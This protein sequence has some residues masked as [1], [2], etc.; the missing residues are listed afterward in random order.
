MANED[1]PTLGKDVLRLSGHIS[2]IE[3][4]DEPQS[5]ELAKYR[6]QLTGAGRIKRGFDWDLSCSRSGAEA[7]CEQ[8]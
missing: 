4:E 3:M 8:I 6:V 5:A 1:K 7:R 2:A